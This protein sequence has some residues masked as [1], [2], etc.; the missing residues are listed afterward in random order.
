MNFASNE[1]VAYSFPFFIKYADED[2]LCEYILR[3]INLLPLK[4]KYYSLIGHEFNSEV[5]ES[6]MTIIGNRSRIEDHQHLIRSFNIILENKLKDRLKYHNQECRKKESTYSLNSEENEEID[7]PD[8]KAARDF[9]EAEL[10]IF[11]QQSKVDDNTMR[12]INLVINS[13]DMISDREA[14]RILNVSRR[15][16][17]NIK[18][19]IKKILEAEM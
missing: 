12:Y 9:L 14:A 5:N 17:A 2:T 4:A 15:Q 1:Y 16:I 7:I 6:L 19:K 3:N 13:E 10:I 11:F 18:E 8:P